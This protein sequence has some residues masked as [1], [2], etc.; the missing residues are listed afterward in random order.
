MQKRLRIQLGAQ[1]KS[2]RHSG[3]RRCTVNYSIIAWFWRQA[4]ELAGAGDRARISSDF[5]AQLQQ[6]PSGNRLDHAASAEET[7]VQVTSHH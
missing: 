7:R 6:H 3:Q 4:G 2:I 1:G 5:D